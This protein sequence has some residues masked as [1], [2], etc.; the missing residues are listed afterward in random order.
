MPAIK[1]GAREFREQIARFPIS[2]NTGC[3]HAH[4]FSS[5]EPGYLLV[6]P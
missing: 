4:A 5:P 1:V 2:E 3:I 6:Y